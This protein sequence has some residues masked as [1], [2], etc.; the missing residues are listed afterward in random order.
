MNRRQRQFP[1]EVRSVGDL[2][3]PVGEAIRRGQPEHSIWSIVRIP[4]HEYPVRRTAWGLELPFGWRT[5]PDRTLAFG[6]QEI[7]AVEVDQHGILTVTPIPLDRLVEIH[8][9]EVLLYA[10]IEFIWAGSA[11]IETKQIEYNSVGTRL[12][13]RAVDQVRD[14]FPPCLP[15]RA[16][17]QPEI[18][19][20]ELPLKFRNH[21]RSS[22]IP[23][24]Q[25]L[26]VT[27]QPAIRRQTGRLHPFLSP[28]RALAITE[29]CLIS[30]EDQ[31]H[32]KR[33]LDGVDTD[34]SVVRR[35]YPLS[36]VEQLTV[37]PA[38]EAYRLDLRL[39]IGDVA[40]ETAFPLAPAGAQ[41]LRGVLHD[42]GSM[43]PER[44]LG[45]A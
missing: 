19:L 28:N 37:D 22:L 16:H 44:G 41:A 40:H 6:E 43:V 42:Q 24:E 17:S 32:R 21:L 31:R 12:I 26:A 34:Y 15:P 20:A 5:T 25:L 2:P 18:S 45:R 9:V 39:G 29:R 14:A 33:W 38:P 3:E 10:F 30:V 35:F 23:A 11:R 13:Q 7:T 27:Y 4:P 36:R 8:V 1:T